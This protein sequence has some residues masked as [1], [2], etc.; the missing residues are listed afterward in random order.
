[1]PNKIRILLLGSILNV[2][3]GSTAAERIAQLN[4]DNP[5]ATFSVDAAAASHMGG[6]YSPKEQPL[7][8]SPQAPLKFTDEE[9]NRAREAGASVDWRKHSAVGPVQQQHPFGTCWAFSMIAVTEAINV[10]Q[11]K[12]PFQKLSEQ[13]MI[14]CV[15]QT[16]CGDNSDVLW[17]VV[18]IRINRMPLMRSCT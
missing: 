17:Y 8:D 10:I 6:C 16:A 1:M 14:S 13:M 3:K 12:N 9:L 18:G 7:A 11:G 15:P 2:S 4:A 5:Y